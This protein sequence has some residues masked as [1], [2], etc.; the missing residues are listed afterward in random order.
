MAGSPLQIVPSRVCLQCDV[1]CRFPDPDSFLRP[2]FTAAER[3]KALAAGLS[4]RH[5]PQ[6]NGGQ[7]ELVPNPG[8]EGYIC[9]AFDPATS[10]CT[11]Y[12][13]RPLDCRLYPFAL[14]WDATG[15]DVLLGWDTKCPFMRDAPPTEIQQAADELAGWVTAEEQLSILEQNPRLVGRYQSDVVVLCALRP[16]TERLLCI[17]AASEP[18]PLNMQDKDRFDQAVNQVVPRLGLPLAAFSFAYHYM[19]HRVLRYSW[20]EIEGHFCLFAQSPDGV[21]LALP[22]LGTGPLEP[23]LTAAFDWMKERNRGSSVTRMENVPH[24][25]IDDIRELGYRI[26]ARHPDYVYD[27][28][29]LVAL[30]GDAHKSQ[31]AAWNRFVRE[32]QG[33]VEP[34][35]TGDRDACLELFR[36]WI[37]QKEQVEVDDYGRAL[38]QDAGAAHD[39]LLTHHALLGLVGAVVRVRGRIRAYTF[40]LWLTP[41]VFCVLLE[42]ADRTIP[43]L[44]AF[45]FREFC[46]QAVTD[47]AQWVNTMDDSGLPSLAKSKHLY[48]P[49]HLLQNYCVTEP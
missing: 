33:T 5:L 6:E 48:H 20:R 41:T 13:V 44:A 29:D 19:W 26:V 4:A 46:R 10:H 45:I 32:Q 34:Y 35:R 47:G 17:R 18:W 9:P 8:G 23:A 7:I 27:A 43:G 28:A 42:V 49:T 25:L 37:A 11:I 14:M 31:R 38:L 1:C 24:A 22:P 30:S 40:G 39:E 3:Q 21:F 16:V 15:K 36:D 12:E 2:F